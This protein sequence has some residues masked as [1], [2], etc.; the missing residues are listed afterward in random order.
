MINLK[1]QR[2]KIKNLRKED[3]LA[4]ARLQNS[5]FVLRYN[6]MMAKDEKTAGAYLEAL[7]NND[8]ALGIYLDDGI[9]IGEINIEEDSLRFGVHSAELSYW[10][11]KPY[12]RCGYMS[13]ALSLVISH[14]F[15]QNIQS[16]T[17][18]CFSV[19]EPSINLLRKLHF[20]KEGH[21]KAAICG[22]QNIIF[23][24]TLWSLTKEKWFGGERDAD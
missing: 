19:N 5:E 8:N 7:A 13:E 3:A 1:S 6:A 17:A 22:Y 23:D 16:I 15:S 11:G 12:A 9:F 10:I 4:Y 24:D 2:L 18:R 20:E 14:L 21:L